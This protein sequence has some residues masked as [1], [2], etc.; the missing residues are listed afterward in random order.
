MRHLGRRIKTTRESIGMTQE[1]LARMCGVSRRQV[2]YWESGQDMPSLPKFRKLCIALEFSADELLNI[3]GTQIDEVRHA[4]RDL[5]ART[6]D[7][8]G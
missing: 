2:V 8:G 7:S 1:T 6:R 3:P 4:R 5:R